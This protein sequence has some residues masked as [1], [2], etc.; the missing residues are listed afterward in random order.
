LGRHSAE[1][2]DERARAMAESRPEVLAA[3]K[4]ALRYGASS[5][6]VEAMQQERDLSRAP[7]AHCSALQQ[8]ED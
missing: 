1:I 4:R 7:T 3:A 5:T 6:R 8:E 2:L